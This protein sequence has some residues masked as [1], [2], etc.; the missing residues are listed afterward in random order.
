MDTLYKK[1]LSHIQHQLTGIERE[2]KHIIKTDM[3]GGK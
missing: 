2:K 3:N 1:Q